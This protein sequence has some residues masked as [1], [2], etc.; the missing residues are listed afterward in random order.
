M[1]TIFLHLGKFQPAKVG[2][3]QPAET[4]EYSTG[5]DTEGCSAA[6][7]GPAVW[8]STARTGEIFWV[9]LLWNDAPNGRIQA[10]L[11]LFDVELP[12]VIK[13]AGEADGSELDDGF[14]HLLGPAHAG[15]LHPVFDQVFARTFDRATGDRPAVGEMF[16]ISACW[17]GFSKGNRRLP[18][19]FYPRLRAGRV[20]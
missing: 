5:V 17:C 6:W 15:T 8:P 19:A 11:I 14:S 10:S 12:V 16:V 9:W 1:P 4:G 20:W 18:A 2:N 13:V 3:F 7:A